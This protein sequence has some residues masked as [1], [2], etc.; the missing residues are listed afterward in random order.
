VLAIEISS[1]DV[2][3][4]HPAEVQPGEEQGAKTEESRKR[5]E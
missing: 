5:K 1:L 2:I 3:R 4:L